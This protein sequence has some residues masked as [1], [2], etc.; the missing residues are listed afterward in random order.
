M[1]RAMRNRHQKQELIRFRRNQVP[2]TM[3]DSGERVIIGD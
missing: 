3:G 1:G 2:E